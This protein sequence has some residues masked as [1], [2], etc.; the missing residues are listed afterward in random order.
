MM[1]TSFTSLSWDDLE[2]WAGS[3][4]LGRGKRYRHRVHDL[5]M[6]DA[7][8]LVASVA[9]R[10]HYI[11]HVWQKNGETDCDCSCPYWGPCK[12]AVA[13][14]LVYL[15]R[16]KSKTPTPQITADALDARL[17]VYGMRDEPTVEDDTELDN[18][19]LDSIDLDKARS[20]LKKMTKAQLIE[21]ILQGAVDHPPLLN[22]LPLS[23]PPLAGDTLEKTVARLRQQIRKTTSERGWQ[24]YW[25]NVGSTP[26][27]SSIQKPLKKLL[28]DGHSET[29]LELGE[30]L[31][32]LGMTQVEESDDEG[33]TAGELS[34]CLAV[35]LDAMRKS[36]RSSAERMIWYWNKLLCDEFSLLDQLEPPIDNAEMNQADWR[37]V[38]NEFTRRLANHPKPKKENGWSSEQYHRQRLLQ[39][40]LQALSYSGENDRALDLMIAELP[41]S[42]NYLELVEFLI[43]NKAYDQAKHWAHRGFKE[44]IDSSPGIAKKLVEQLLGIARQHKDWPQVAALQVDTFLDTTTTDHY[45][46]AKTSCK[47][48][49]CWQKVECKLLQFLE[50]GDDPL[51]AKDW[52]LPA[53]KLKFPTRQNRRNFPDYNTLID[54]ALHEKRIEDALH[55]FQQA[56]HKNYHADTIAHLVQKSHPEISLDIWQHEIEELIAQVK[57]RAYQDAMPY[58]KK[59][60]TLL[61]NIKRS[62][63]YRHYILQLRTQHKAKRRL[64]KELDTLENQGKKTRLIL[65]D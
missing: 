12:H 33:E 43:A 65:D 55:W 8:H 42:N 3:T 48:S 39:Y 64:M 50:T 44:T 54:I 19:E 9:G 32:T 57:P 47:K 60:R 28:N 27:Y 34:E 51:S 56:P 29:V 13:V 49:K 10:E 1:T 35:V 17:S 16:I 53:T 11:T 7:E 26:D 61:R 18:L 30:E 21:W 62:D 36:D 5:E 22:T 4:I 63:D 20:A 6:T 24:D 46:L 25:N 14:I 37:T 40:T 23:S 59:M 52:P 31:F 45:Q 38:T 41:Y 58:L 2:Q 15:D